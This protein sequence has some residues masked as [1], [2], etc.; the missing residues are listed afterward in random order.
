MK[1]DFRRTLLSVAFMM[2]LLMLWDHWHVVHGEPSMFAPRPPVVATTPKLPSTTTGAENAAMSAAAASGAQSAG[3]SAAELQ[4]QRFTIQ[5]DVIKATLDTRGGDLIDLDLL[6]Y[7][8][9]YS[10]SEVLEAAKKLIGM[11]PAPH[12]EGDVQVF[13]T[14]PDQF[15]A[16]QTGL[17]DAK[18]GALPNQTTVMKLVSTER[19]LADGKNEL[20]LR[21]ESPD[22]GG[23]QLVKT[24][25]FHRGSYAIDVAHE[26]VNHTNA[27]ISPDLYLRRS[28]AMA[29]SPP[30]ATSTARARTPAPRSTATASSTRSLSPTST[31]ARRRTP[32]I[33][34]PARATAGSR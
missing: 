28:C 14:A 17:A 33:R 10:H 8:Q 12:P 3:G 19:A 34:T 29:A 11:T 23:V 30:A 27:P 21:F 9:T 7:Q 20:A 13:D 31:R 6:K 2:S 26:V 32:S 22:V 25:T 5:T 18:N 4:A 24:Y 15:Y 1:N 16:A